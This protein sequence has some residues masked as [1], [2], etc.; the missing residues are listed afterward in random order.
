MLYEIYKFPFRVMLFYHRNLVFGVDFSVTLFKFLTLIKGNYFTNT[1]ELLVCGEK[2]L[3][4]LFCLP[5]FSPSQFS[6]LNIL[7]NIINA[8]VC[9]P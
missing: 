4:K 1:M 2:N 5:Y 6:K 9:H 7:F 3:L 8:N